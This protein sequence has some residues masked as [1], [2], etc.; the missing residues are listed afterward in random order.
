M[1]SR[2]FAG[3]AMT[4]LLVVTPGRIVAQAAAPSHEAFD[5][6]LRRH[7]RGGLVDYDAF[8]RAPEFRAYLD[9]LARTDPAT[10][11]R[12][13]QLALWINAYNAYTIQQI[14]AHHERRSIKNINKTGGLLSLGGAWKEAMA[15][16]G[17][18]RYTLDQIEHERIRPVFREPRVHFALVCAAMGCPPLRSEAYRAEALDQQLDDQAHEFLVR[19]PGKNRV[20][21]SRKTVWLSPIFKWYRKDFAD[22]D[23]ALLQ[24]LARY[25]PPGAERDL[26]TSGKARITWTE[27]DW[28]LNRASREPNE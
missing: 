16:V 4:V 11:P 24:A 13:E 28:S 8:E 26:L 15:T 20:D 27:Y 23:A 5:T 3:I 25:I 17:G 21:A 6:L 7:V 22:T 1:T 18:T 10:L 9:L 14:N 2:I 19:S 12:A